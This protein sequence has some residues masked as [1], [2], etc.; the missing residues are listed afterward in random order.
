[1]PDRSITHRASRDRT[2][3]APA[4]LIEFLEA[5]A[6]DHH[7]HCLAAVRR[8]LIDEVAADLD[9]GGWATPSSSEKSEPEVGFEPTT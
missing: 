1:M 2:Y 9:A 7:R 3:G 4:V 5:T 8:H 6:R